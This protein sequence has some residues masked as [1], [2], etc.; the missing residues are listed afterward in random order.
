MNRHSSLTVNLWQPAKHQLHLF[1]LENRNQALRNKLVEPREKRLNLVLY[2]FGHLR[3]AV[4]AH[5]LFLVF[6]GDQFHFASL[7]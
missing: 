5:V 2:L 6:L 3:V 4:G 1:P 7:H